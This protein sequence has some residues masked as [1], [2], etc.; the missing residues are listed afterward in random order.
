VND[1]ALQLAIFVATG[2][3]FLGIGVIWRLQ[4]GPA[5]GLTTLPRPGR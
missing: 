5:R 3:G 2:A 1:P 4:M